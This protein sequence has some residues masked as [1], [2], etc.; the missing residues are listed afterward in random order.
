MVHC[1]VIS[2][3]AL[4]FCFNLSVVK[5]DEKLEF[6]KQR[7][8]PVLEQR[9]YSCHSGAADSIKGGLRLDSKPAIRRG[10]ENGPAVVPGNVDESLLIAALRYEGLEMPPNEPQRAHQYGSRL[11]RTQEPS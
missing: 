2:C 6:F 7:I 3:A 8:E 10:G 1:R 9:C 5:A 11:L 4:L